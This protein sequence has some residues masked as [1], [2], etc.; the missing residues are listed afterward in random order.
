[1]ATTQPP[2]NLVVVTGH[3]ITAFATAR[4]FTQ[5]LDYFVPDDEPEQ[6]RNGRHLRKCIRRFYPSTACDFIIHINSF[7]KATRA[8]RNVITQFRTWVSSD[9]FKEYLRNNGT[10]PKNQLIEVVALLE[11]AQASSGKLLNL[12]SN[13]TP[14]LPYGC[15]IVAT[16]A[17]I[18]ERANSFIDTEAC[19]VRTCPRR[20]PDLTSSV[21]MI[22][23]D[24]SLRFFIFRESTAIIYV[25][26]RGTSAAQIVY[27]TRS[28]RFNKI[29][30]FLEN[31]IKPMLSRRQELFRLNL[32]VSL[33]NR[34]KTVFTVKHNA[35][36]Q[37]I[38]RLIKI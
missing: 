27:Y 33:L 3:T 2:T 12:I 17:V 21:Y 23:A 13:S 8:A 38:R 1:M 36:P 15:G 30:G 31:T 37:E 10:L 5:P 22:F 35:T 18:I 7:T 32:A 24:N 16:R 28:Q 4:M 20:V 14:N 6:I 34:K 25:A 11:V 29:T 26:Q 9:A 19:L